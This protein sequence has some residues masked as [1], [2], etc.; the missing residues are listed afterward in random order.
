MTSDPSTSA[1]TAPTGDDAARDAEIRAVVGAAVRRL[2]HAVVGRH[3]DPDLL[4]EVARTADALSSR[5]EDA[6]ARRRSPTTFRGDPRRVPDDG[7]RVLT[8]ADRPV[9]G[10]ASPWGLD[11]VL[12][13]QGDGVEGSL[14]LDAAHE[15]AP[16]RSHGGIV[17]ALFDDVLGTLL[18]VNGLR[19]YTGELTVR[20]LAP[21]PL[22]TA[23]TIRARIASH[24]GRK[25]VTEGS[26]SDGDTVLATARALFIAVLPPPERAG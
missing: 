2:G 5:L 16:G 4:L 12:T 20:Y 22:H 13:R 18:Q 7:G 6:P 19:G 17:S 11:L 10:I 8:H 9:S 14:R 3:A 23:L 15:G 26:L 21:T 25:I 1:I 24:E